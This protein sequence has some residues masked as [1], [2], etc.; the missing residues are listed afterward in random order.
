MGIEHLILE[1]CI[2]NYLG[3]PRMVSLRIA[4]LAQVLT[5]PLRHNELPP[6]MHWYYRGDSFWGSGLFSTQL[7][8]IEPLGSKR[9]PGLCAAWVQGFRG[10]MIHLGFILL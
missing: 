3:G 6:N 10:F 2:L 5:R 4:P 1:A 7:R 8:C 9:P